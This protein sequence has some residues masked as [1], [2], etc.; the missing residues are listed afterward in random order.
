MEFYVHT[1]IFSTEVDPNATVDH[2]HHIDVAFVPHLYTHAKRVLDASRTRYHI[3]GIVPNA[4]DVKERPRVMGEIAAALPSLRE[5]RDHDNKFLLFAPGESHVRLLGGPLCEALSRRPNVTL[6]DIDP[7]MGGL[8]WNQRFAPLYKKVLVA[9]YFVRQQLFTR[10]QGHE[11]NITSMFHGDTGRY[12]GGKRGAVR[13]I[14]K[15]VPRSEYRST[16]GIRKNITA[17]RS[18]YQQTLY[19]MKRSQTCMCPSGDTPTSRRLYES[20]AS[21]CVPIRID[22]I[23]DRQLPFHNL[24]PW[25][26]VTF[27]IEPSRMSLTQRHSSASSDIMRDRTRE[28]KRVF[29]ISTSAGLAETRRL[30]M[31][32]ADRYMNPRRPHGFI[33]AL[34][35]HWR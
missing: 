17:L 2:Q 23:P 35:M 18:A 8:R 33:D 6:V 14:L 10:D 28:A 3:L 7:W 34:L 27:K 29:E 12:D 9:P 25:G 26:D 30:G 24:V 22:R 5:W 15:H 1:G 21:G 20:L 4:V 11:R 16:Y 13:D 32:A 19:S 31:Q